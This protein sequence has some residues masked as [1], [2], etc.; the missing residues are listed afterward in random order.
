VSDTKDASMLPPKREVALALVQTA[1][2][3]FIHLDPRPADV[4]VPSWFKSQPELVLQVGLS[5]VPAIVDLDI[6]QDAL[7]ATLSFNRRPEFCRIPW[8]AIWGLV[9]DDG[10]GMIW[11]ESVPPE[12]A[13]RAPGRP[14][15]AKSGSGKTAPGKTGSA[16]TGSV[17]TAPRKLGSGQVGSGKAGGAHLRAASP[18]TDAAEKANEPPAQAA[19]QPEPAPNPAPASSSSPPAKRELP[20]YLRIVK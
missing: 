2:S 10:R 1:A 3:V 4:N 19:G 6:G 11:P 17:K 15:Q 7:S 16:K 9:G 14:N 12:V 5:L 13:A 20:P 8:S 18:P